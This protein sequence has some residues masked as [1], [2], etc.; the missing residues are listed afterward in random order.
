MGQLSSGDAS[1]FKSDLVSCFQY[2]KAD[3]RENFNEMDFE[4]ADK[5][6]KME[7]YIS[8]IETK[9]DSMINVLNSI[10]FE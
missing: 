5:E 10:G 9:F 2:K 6:T 4:N 7:E 1:R 3:I 8:S